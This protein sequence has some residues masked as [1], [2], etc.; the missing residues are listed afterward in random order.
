[1][2]WNEST[3]K[4]KAIKR[5]KIANR[6]KKKLANI[7]EPRSRGWEKT[8]EI[9]MEG[10]HRKENSGKITGYISTWEEN[11]MKEVLKLPSGKR[12]KRHGNFWAGVLT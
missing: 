4:K 1:M 5:R 2:G 10:M 6:E 12:E 8:V 9:G 3:H 11:K 7:K